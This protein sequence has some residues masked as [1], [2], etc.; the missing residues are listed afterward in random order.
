MFGTSFN[1]AGN[2]LW[3][4][5][6]NEAAD[7]V[8]W[9]GVAKLAETLLA[10]AEQHLD[11]KKIGELDEIKGGFSET[12]EL[13]TSEETV[14]LGFKT[15]SYTGFTQKLQQSDIAK[16][17]VLLHYTAVVY[18]NGSRGLEI[19]D[20]TG[21]KRFLADHTA[22]IFT[23]IY[24]HW[25]AI[26]NAPFTDDPI[27][28]VVGMRKGIGKLKVGAAVSLLVADRLKEATCEG[29]IYWYTVGGA[30]RAEPRPYVLLGGEGTLHKLTEAPSYSTIREP[31]IA[32]AAKEFRQFVAVFNLLLANSNDSFGLSE[33]AVSSNMPLLWE[34]VEDT[35]TTGLS[36]R[37][38]RLDGPDERAMETLFFYPLVHKLW[39]ISHQVK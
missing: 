1:F 11:A 30:D 34:R 26:R 38:R 9:N 36:R 13:S 22:R 4:S 17:M 20:V 8:Q 37:R 6:F 5:G 28:T 19:L 31:E 35:I 10:Q 14:N 39:L 18:R 24:E 7:K 15:D 23:L 12:P 32:A 21:D 16:L 2:G 3:G 33:N 25:D 27:A 29:G